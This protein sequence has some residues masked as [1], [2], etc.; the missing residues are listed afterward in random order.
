M[1]LVLLLL[2][3]NDVSCSRSGFQVDPPTGIRGI[4]SPI[5]SSGL[6]SC[7]P[8]GSISMSANFSYC[9]LKKMTSY[10]LY[11][12]VPSAPEDPQVDFHLSK[13]QSK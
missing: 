11:P 2:P 13:I 3:L 4:F 5:G 7:S 12:T 1:S 10:N 9:P 6:D 8:K